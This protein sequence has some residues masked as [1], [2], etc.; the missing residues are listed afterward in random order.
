MSAKQA[1][2]YPVPEEKEK[3]G[4]KAEDHITTVSATSI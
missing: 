2:R 3:G 4:K 1:V